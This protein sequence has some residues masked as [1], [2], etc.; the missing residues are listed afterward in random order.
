MKRF[1]VGLL[2]ALLVAS[3]SA[4][5]PDIRPRPGDRPAANPHST[6]SVVMGRNGMIATSQPL[7]S[8]A[9]LKVLQDGGNAIDAAVTAA[10]VL[11]CAL[12]SCNAAIRSRTGGA[13]GGFQGILLDPRTGVLMG[14]SDVRKDGL[15][16]V[17]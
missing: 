3:T 10:A 17:Y 4:Q 1:Y 12:R 8:A 15:A 16:I 5:S 6:R 11:P 14:G 2:A 9:G 13:F 7:A